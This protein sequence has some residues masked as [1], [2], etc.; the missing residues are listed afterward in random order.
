MLG[1]GSITY[2]TVTYGTVTYGTVVT[3]CELWPPNKYGGIPIKQVLPDNGSLGK[4]GREQLAGD[5][6]VWQAS[7]VNPDF[8]GYARSCGATGICV[9]HAP[10]SMTVGG[11]L[12]S[13]TGR[14]CC[15]C[16]ATHVGVTAGLIIGPSALV[17]VQPDETIRALSVLRLSFLLFLAGFEVDVRRS[18]GHTGRQALVGLIG[19]LMLAC[20][21]HPAP[22]GCAAGY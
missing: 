14:H 5:L 1:P 17:W 9:G 20:A 12:F 13:L 16:T 6:P 8:A 7:L 2:G 11:N 3:A 21:W 22:V 18:R 10:T 19:S 15:T 4:I